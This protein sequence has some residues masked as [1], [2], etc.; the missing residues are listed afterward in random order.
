[1]AFNSNIKGYMTFGKSFSRG[2][3]FPLEAYEIWTN[4]DELVAYAANTNPDKDPSYIG[5]KVAYVDLE[6]K[7]VTHYGI[8][9]DGTLKELGVTPLG[10]DSSITVNSAGLIKLFGFDGAQAGTVAVKENGKLVW[11]TLEE[12]GA[13]DGNDNTTYT[14]AP[15]PEEYE[16]EVVGFVVQEYF[17]GVAKG[18]P[19]GI[20]LNTYTTSQID[21]KFNDALK[22]E[23][24]IPFATDDPNTILICETTKYRLWTNPETPQEKYIHS[25]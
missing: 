19:F 1:M 21:E 6:N 22:A 23:T 17:N 3:A 10:D 14:F 11:K 4:Y 9:V 20:Q 5:Q 13:G 18:E 7:K 25:L 12:I 15:V 8:E 16:D 24:G 2:G